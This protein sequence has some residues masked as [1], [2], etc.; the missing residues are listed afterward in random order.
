M[1]MLTLLLGW[2][3]PV[4]CHTTTTSTTSSTT[5]TSSS[6]S[7]PTTPVI[8]GSRLAATPTS[9]ATPAAADT[10]PKITLLPSVPHPTTPSYL[11]SPPSTTPFPTATPSPS[12]FPPAIVSPP[13]PPT[14]AASWFHHTHGGAGLQESASPEPLLHE[15]SLPDMPDA[16]RPHKGP[17]APPRH[18]QPPA[19]LPPQHSSPPKAD[20]VPHAGGRPGE[21]RREAWGGV[22]RQKVGL[23][24]TGVTDFPRPP[25][26]AEARQRSGREAHLG[27]LNEQV[28]SRGPQGTPNPGGGREGALHP[29]AG[30]STLRA[31]ADSDVTTSPPALEGSR[32]ELIDE[33]GDEGVQATLG[34]CIL[35]RKAPAAPG[36]A[37]PPVSR[38]LIKEKLRG[39]EEEE[40][41][42]EELEEERTQQHYE[43]TVT[44]SDNYVEDSMIN[45]GSVPPREGGGWAARAWLRQRKRTRRRDGEAAHRG[46]RGGGAS[47]RSSTSTAT[48]RKAAGGGAAMGRVR[49]LTGP[50]RE[51]RRPSGELRPLDDLDSDDGGLS[52][53][54][55]T[56]LQVAASPLP[57]PDPSLIPGWGGG[58]NSPSNAPRHGEGAAETHNGSQERCR[59]A[60]DASQ[61]EGAGKG[62]QS[63]S[64]RPSAPLGF[65]TAHT[66]ATLYHPQPFNNRRSP[67]PRPPPKQPEKSNIP[68]LMASTDAGLKAR[69]QRPED[70]LAGTMGGQ[71]VT[72][73]TPQSA[74]EGQ[75]GGDI[76]PPATSQ[77]PEE[78][79]GE[80]E[81]EELLLV[82]LRCPNEG[83]ETLGMHAPY[84]LH[85]G[86]MAFVQDEEEQQQQ[87]QL[88]EEDQ[89]NIH[90]KKEEYQGKRSV[91][92]SKGSFGNTKEEQ[93]T[94]D[95]LVLMRLFVN[96][97]EKGEKASGEETAI[98]TQEGPTTMMGRKSL[99]EVAERKADGEGGKTTPS[100]SPYPYGSPPAFNP[101]PLPPWLQGST[102]ISIKDFSSTGKFVE[103]ISSISSPNSDPRRQATPSAA[104]GRGKVPSSLRD[105][106]G[107]G[108][109][110]RCSHRPAGPPRVL[111][112][113]SEGRAV[114]LEGAGRG[115]GRAP[116]LRP[117][118]DVLLCHALLPPWLLRPAVAL[119]FGSAA[120]LPCVSGA[121]Q[122]DPP[123]RSHR[124]R[125]RHNANER[126]ALS[127]ILVSAEVVT[128]IR[129]S[130]IKVLVSPPPTE[131]PRREEGHGE[132]PRRHIF[133]WR[134][135]GTANPSVPPVVVVYCD[136]V[137]ATKRCLMSLPR[138]SAASPAH[139]HHGPSKGWWRGKRSVEVPQTDDRTSKRKDKNRRQ[140]ERRR[141]S[142][143]K[144]WKF[145]VKSHSRGQ[146]RGRR[147]RGARQA[148]SSFGE[149]QESASL[150]SSWLAALTRRSHKGGRRAEAANVQHFVNT[151][152][153]QGYLAR[154]DR[155]FPPVTEFQNL[156]DRA[157]VSSSSLNSNRKVFEVQ[158]NFKHKGRAERFSPPAG[159]FRPRPPRA[160]LTPRRAQ[161]SPPRTA[162]RL[163]FSSP[164]REGWRPSLA[165][166][167]TDL[168]DPENIPGEGA[169]H[170]EEKRREEGRE[171]VRT[172][173]LGGEAASGNISLLS[174]ASGW[175][176]GG[177][178]T[179]APGVGRGSGHD[180]VTDVSDQRGGG[181]QDRPVE[182]TLSP[183]DPRDNAES[184]DRPRAS[185][186]LTH[187]L[188]ARDPQ[189]AAVQSVK[190][191]EGAPAPGWGVRG[192]GR[193]EKTVN[194]IEGI[195][196]SEK[197]REL[198]RISSSNSII[199]N[200][201]NNN[202]NNN[203]KS[204][205]NNNNNNNN[206][207]NGS[208]SNGSNNMDN[209]CSDS[210][211]N[212]FNN[213]LVKA[214]EASGITGSSGAFTSGSKRYGGRKEKK[215]EEIKL[216][217]NK[218]DSNKSTRSGDAPL[219]GEAEVLGGA[220]ARQDQPGGGTGLGIAAPG[221][222]PGSARRWPAQNSSLI[223]EAMSGAPRREV[224]TPL[225]ATLRP[226]KLQ[227]EQTLT[228]GEGP[229]GRL[230]APSQ[231]P[232]QEKQNKPPRPYQLRWPSDY[233]PSGPWAAR[234]RGNFRGHSKT[235]PRAHR[236]LLPLTHKKMPVRTYWGL[237]RDARE[238]A[239]ERRPS[240][241]LGQEGGVPPPKGGVQ[242]H[243]GENDQS[244]LHGPAPAGAVVGGERRPHLSQPSSNYQ[245]GPREGRARLAAP[246]RAHNPDK[247]PPGGK[248]ADD[249]T[250]LQQTGRRSMIRTGVA[251][252]APPMRVVP[253]LGL[254]DLTVRGEPRLGGRSELAAAQLA[255][256]HINEQQVIPGHTLVM[257]HNDTQCDSGSG[258]DAFFH[259]LY[260]SRARMRILLGAACTEVTESLAAVVHY[261]NIVQLER[262]DEQQD[263]MHA[264]YPGAYFKSLYGYV[265]LE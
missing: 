42:E 92:Q 13:A 58:N 180:N 232:R 149:A 128:N 236:P 150:Y 7:S 256:R 178:S 170:Q 21:G 209:H 38:S 176:R 15:A 81:E 188:Q 9:P 93:T 231:Y 27:R 104:R 17:A 56:H 250:I 221:L 87:Q 20:Q 80:E 115:A 4:T 34:P 195:N 133:I 190:R 211:Q 28:F 60:A 6:V 177:N 72:G 84:S 25:F 89:V 74:S 121:P 248:G 239:A 129:K 49:R 50:V 55:Y 213:S 48:S 102:N 143:S 164:G 54:Q 205:N 30:V 23:R 247:E 57:R 174:H 83:E 206:D 259:A 222:L 106:G 86:V 220:A 165:S 208:S 197:D 59:L 105:R 167:V 193:G 24:M 41:E 76:K 194:D 234:V 219:T 116:G 255:L 151:A 179:A 136:A 241:P 199:I 134:S 262:K 168:R 210:S 227:P 162:S 35:C 200:N 264:Y 204:S 103:K 22:P 230:S 154:R 187:I 73:P 124:R 137:N 36:P 201:N 152:L 71:N 203:N 61:G 127:S 228:P 198:D 117:C 252:T 139:E 159:Y 171:T 94:A 3:D 1:M 184:Y 135:G 47:V 147:R 214:E 109:T 114:A 157:K 39:E 153:A 10:P 146:H 242:S 90:E 263:M 68:P 254:F 130:F 181:S 245:S 66:P 186:T 183:D 85:E 148:F 52:G 238:E 144:A 233:L 160:T 37:A 16:S 79:E 251:P 46:E 33:A 212:I 189:E 226:S 141:E 65:P 253:I 45:I 51:A 156:T 111:L 166:L 91:S 131:A 237:N 172:V 69:G 5:L 246:D 261:W 132:G 26:D 140:P 155:T 107:P 31:Q 101:R 229:G 100:A 163:S 70:R 182:S 225:A 216:I 14:T 138:V 123:V 64:S 98:K 145:I 118:P 126:V 169:V 158:S 161:R 67:S 96:Q 218:G 125:S 122:S 43:V 110:Q 257:F 108:M 243:R 19:T 78:E 223:K 235:Y 120:P 88:H 192:A 75:V 77:V 95:L 99:P 196:T 53:T 40:E 240:S 97:G 8:S 191:K 82:V 207:N 2:Q 258:V 202:N 173:S 63:V 12:A 62:A 224:P 244:S 44:K 11:D 215:N 217:C 249:P 18:L 265:V 29:D 113:D 142:Y 112:L 119:R 185:A 260:T 32:A 175:P